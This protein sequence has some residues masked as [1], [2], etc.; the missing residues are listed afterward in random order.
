MLSM[1]AAA[2]AAAMALVRLAEVNP[3]LNGCGAQCMDLPGLQQSGHAE[4]EQAI[5]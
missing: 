4:D 1:A 3:L 2:T 5:G